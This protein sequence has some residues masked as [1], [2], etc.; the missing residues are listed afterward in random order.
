VTLRPDPIG[1]IP[2]ETVRVARAAIP[3]GSR[4][5]QMRDALGTI[6]TNVDFAA[7]YPDRGRPV[8]TP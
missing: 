5:P 1:P 3:H 7:L 4:Y 2:A 6:F 8:E